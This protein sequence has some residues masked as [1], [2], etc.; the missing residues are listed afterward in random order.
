MSMNYQ[1]PTPSKYVKQLLDSAGYKKKLFGKKVLEN[2]CGEGN[3]LY[4]IVDRYIKDS[5]TRNF[6]L[7]DIKNGLQRDIVAYEIDFEKIAIC[8]NRLDNLCLEY[9]IF[10][11]N[12]SINQIDYL[13]SNTE[14]FD[15]IVGN[16]PY[17]TYH[18]MTE[19]QREN[20][21]NKFESCKKG[22]FDYCYAFIEKSLKSLTS[23]GV[24]AYLIPYGVLRNQYA[25]NIRS[26]ILP[27]LIDLYDYEGI[28]VFE[29]VISSSVVIVCINNDVEKSFKYHK[30]IN[31]TSRII[32]KNTLGDKWFFERELEGKKRFGDYFEVKN[33]IATLCNKA[34]IISGYTY[35]NDY[36]YVGEDKI[37][38]SLVYRAVSAK[39][40]RN[41]NNTEGIIFPYQVKKY[42]YNNFPS[43]TY[44]QETYPYAY[45]Y[46]KKFYSL[47]EKRK[48]SESV[49]WFEYGRTQALN[50]IFGKKL[51]MSQIVT[52]KVNLYMCEDMDIPYAGYFIKSKDDTHSLEEAKSILESV[53]F[54]E[55]V[56]SHGTPTTSVSYRISVKEILDYTY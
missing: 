7:S 52:Q 28:S 18:H 56:K 32:A 13:L 3:V 16:P 48:S 34:Y 15:F 53:R 33:S 19:V 46:L 2:S 20:L 30:K 37:E 24:L 51:I 6:E 43:E 39:N 36:V 11:V 55:Y 27:G 35:D 41:L 31:N 8:K 49:K 54:F 42:K 44:F 4:E 45:T 9:G 29:D 23:G 12:W 40:K 50:Q 26:Q 10:N 47:L 22:R 17:I 25:T 38:K 1:I 5:L 21:R 14:T